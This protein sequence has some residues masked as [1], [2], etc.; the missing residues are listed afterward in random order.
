MRGDQLARQWRILRRIEANRHGLTA[1]EIAAAVD[2]SLRTVYRDLETLQ[3][4]GFPLY[5]G[6]TDTGKRWRF[7]AGWSLG[8]SL[9]LD[10]NEMVGLHLSR[11]VLA[12]MGR[13][14]RTER[15]QV[16]GGFSSD[17]SEWWIFSAL[18]DRHPRLHFANDTLVEI[19]IYCWAF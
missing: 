2:V 6:K 9:P 15:V 11:E 5:T 4:A 7:V 17:P 3:E 16:S 14:L 10:I 8:N 18:G 13:P 19:G 1:F 12:V